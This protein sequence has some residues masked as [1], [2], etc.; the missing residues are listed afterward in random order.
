MRQCS[1]TA[2]VHDAEVTEPKP[3]IEHPS[4]L[5]HYTSAAGLQGILSPSW[6]S[7]LFVPPTGGG[8]ALLHA[9][10]VRYMNDSVELRFGADLMINR[11]HADAAKH[12][13]DFT[14]VLNRLAEQLEPDLFGQA[15]QHLRAFAACF[16]D[17]GD[18]L[19]QWRGYSGGV[20]GFAIGFPT[21]VLANHAL[22]IIGRPFGG[23]DSFKLEIQPV[24]YGTAAATAAID[25]HLFDLRQNRAVVVMRDGKPAFEWLLGD[26]YRLLARIK[27]GAFSEEREWRLI[28]LVN[29][30]EYM[31]HIPV[32]ARAAGL[33][34]YIHFG[35]NLPVHNGDDYVRP[36]QAAIESVIVGPG[37]DQ[38]AQAWAVGDLLRSAGYSQLDISLSRAPYRG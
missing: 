37:S 18:L 5:Y 29:Q 15:T 20:G 16:C 17:N 4:V 10:D 27:H 31:H 2:P 9:T 1:G 38:Q 33:V 32:R 28:Q 14:E 21:E 22:S 11:L 19:S 23:P 26:V 12:D 8:S 25:Q 35:L 34:P 13:D 30:Q 24:I 7:D 36:M 3:C 6:P